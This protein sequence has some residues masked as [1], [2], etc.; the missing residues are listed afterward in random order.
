MKDFTTDPGLQLMHKISRSFV[1]PGYVA[2][3]DQSDFETN[4]N[5]VSKCAMISP[6]PRLPAH[7]R[8]STWYS[9]ASFVTQ[10]ESS[11]LEQADLDKIESYLKVA[12]E[13]LGIIDDI[14]AVDVTYAASKVASEETSEKFPVRG[15]AEAKA[16]AEAFPA[17]TDAS[18]EE[19]VALAR[20]ISAYG[21][22]N[23]YVKR[24]TCHY[25]CYDGKA[26]ANLLR[27]TENPHA[28]KLAEMCEGL[29]PQEMQEHHKMAA[30]ICEAAG[31]F[32][33]RPEIKLAVNTVEPVAFLNNGSVVKESQLTAANSNILVAAATGVVS[34]GDNKYVK[35]AQDMS[36]ELADDLVADLTAQG[37]SVEV[38]PGD[39]F[40]F[41]ITTL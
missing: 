2:D 15:E 12:A 26:V 4:E 1:V 10:K 36:A 34:L 18:V 28:I 11:E 14:N 19:R 30:E 25:G 16:A 9:Y 40:D 20:K 31:V 13:S 23:D 37:I 7:N 22:D 33:D 8:A 29:S 3:A 24:S 17:I 21:F 32:D 39:G 38:N 5:S 6:E 41:T 27:S 35:A